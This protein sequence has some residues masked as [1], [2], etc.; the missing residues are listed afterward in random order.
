MIL[1]PLLALLQAIPTQAFYGPPH[2]IKQSN[3]L[4]LSPP[5]I[6]SY[7][8]P[9]DT[10]LSR[11]V[12]QIKQRYSELKAH[13]RDFDDSALPVDR[14]LRPSRAGTPMSGWRKRKAEA[15]GAWVWTPVNGYVWVPEADPNQLAQQQKQQKMLRYGK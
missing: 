12:C 13:K 9:G 11:M 10:Q 7:D 2:T 1:L 5:D 15:E 4:A 8:C 3:D 14:F 6:G